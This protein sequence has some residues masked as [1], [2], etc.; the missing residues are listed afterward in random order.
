MG[1]PGVQCCIARASIGIGIV[2]IAF[3][4]C[5]TVSLERIFAASFFSY[6]GLDPCPQAGH[7]NALPS[8]C[9]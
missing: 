9:S 6:R 4:K 3:C 2:S 8:A 1:R 5:K 7:S